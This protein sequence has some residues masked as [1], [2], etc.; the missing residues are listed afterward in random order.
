VKTDFDSFVELV[1]AALKCLLAAYEI[2][3]E[4]ARLHSQI[5]NFKRTGEDGSFRMDDVVLTDL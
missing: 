3:P 1:L 5:I 2:E 4:N